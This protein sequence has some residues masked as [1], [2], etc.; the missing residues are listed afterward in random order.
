MDESSQAQEGMCIEN[1]YRIVRKIAQGGMA[2]VYQAQ[3][4]RLDRPVAIKIMHT[5]LAQGV[6]RQQFIARFRREATSAAAIANPH[7]VQVYDTGEY[8]G[9]D[10]LVMEYVHG[11]NL[12]YEMN[13]QGTF[14]V[15]D[16]LRLL[17]ET[18]DGLA[19]A[20]QAGVVHRDIKP[21][22]ILINDRGHVQITDFGLA[23]AISQATLSST[24]LLLG[25]AAYLAPELIEHNLATPQGDLYSAGMMAWEMLAG[26]VPFTADNPV[27]LVFK[28]VHENTPSISTACPE[29]NEKVAQFISKLTARDMNERPD[30]ASEALAQLRALSKQLQPEDWQ[31]KLQEPEDQ[32]SLL[33]LSPLENLNASAEHADSDSES[34]SDS[35]SDLKSSK[36]ENDTKDINADDFAEN[37]SVNT[38]NNDYDDAT[39]MLKQNKNLSS[40]SEDYSEASNKTYTKTMS[41]N[42]QD[43]PLSEFDD[44]NMP[45]I[46]ISAKNLSANNGS[47]SII[48][49]LQPKDSNNRNSKNSKKKAFIIAGSSA[50]VVL[51]AAIAGGLWYMLG[52]GSYWTLP[53]PDDLQCANRAACKITDINWQQYEHTLKVAGI[54]YTVSQNY[55]DDVP[56]GKVLETNPDVVGGHI[57]KHG[58]NRLRVVLSLG[59]R[60]STIPKDI[61]DPNSYN[62]KN[63]IKALKKAGFTNIVHHKSSDIYSLEIP[64]GSVIDISPDPGT[65]MNHNDE[66]SV[67]LSKGPMPVQMPEVV[68]HTKAEADAALSDAKL[69]VTYDEENSDTV[70]KGKIISSSVDAGTQLHWGDSVKLVVSKGPKTI[71]L[72]NVCGKNTDEARRIIEGLGLQVKISAPLGDFMHVVRFQSPSGGSEVPV[73]D[74]RGNATVVTLTVI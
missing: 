40:S 29:I 35:E 48:P 3:D 22:N 31:Y 60:K 33:N 57:G 19:S 6:H 63:P 67:L 26:R 1:R 14:S 17:A 71:T 24:G 16:T 72:P 56:A 39:I 49:T 68:N 54:P 69:N 46:A 37:S 53:K 66:V 10:Y 65:R 43:D 74:A 61:T 36:D 45:T 4:E 38:E 5:Q 58:N 47:N 20:H 18:L 15:R 64:E 44:S 25:T 34:K 27:T 50:A 9:L 52:P 42:P 32:Q 41:Y 21:E 2:T 23:R 59:I 62:G 28:H 13:T 30:N 7:I 11:V 55:S 51:V 8:E 73:K 70:A 12:R